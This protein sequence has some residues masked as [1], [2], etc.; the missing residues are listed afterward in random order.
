V[1]LM[2]GHWEDS[3]LSFSVDTGAPNIIPLTYARFGEQSRSWKFD[4]WKFERSRLINRAEPL[5]FFA[6]H[7]ID[8][9]LHR[10]PLTLDAPELLFANKLSNDLQ[11][12]LRRKVCAP[13]LLPFVVYTLGPSIG[14]RTP[15]TVNLHSPDTH[16]LSRG[17]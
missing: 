14:I 10:Y 7:P 12:M 8:Y 13:C 4:N 3:V 5:S 17:G 11:D 16:T 1:V 2:H 9:R 6:N 15:R